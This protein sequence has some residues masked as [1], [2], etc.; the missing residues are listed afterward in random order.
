MVFT[1]S[2]KTTARLSSLS[3]TRTAFA[4]V[5]A[6]SLGGA[7]ADEYPRVIRTFMPDAGPSAFAVELSPSLALCYDPLRGGVNQ[8]WQGTIDLTPTFQAKI[9]Q[10]A[11][12]AGETFYREAREHPLRL[13]DPDAPARH[14][15]KGYR[16]ANGAAIFEFTLGG[17]RVS[18]TLRTTPDGRGLVREF[19]LPREAGPGF[20]STEAQDKAQVTITG[21]QEVR[22]GHWRFDAGARVTMTIQP[23]TNAAR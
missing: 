13:A 10:P 1:H 12:I 2:K 4:L 11:K 17:F 15:F 14:R 5:M 9:N 23:K 20:F 8:L 3:P 16:Y 19:A 7:K 18:E 21:G 22:P 6:A